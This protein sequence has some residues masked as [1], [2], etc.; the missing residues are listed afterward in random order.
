MLAIQ[1]HGFLPDFGLVIFIFFLQRLDF[2]LKFLHFIHRLVAHIAQRPE[3]DLDN[4]GQDNNR[5]AVVL[6]KPKQEVENIQS[7]NS[8]PFKPA[9]IDGVFQTD[10][11]C[12]EEIILFG[13]E[14]QRI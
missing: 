8:Q 7:G 13:T 2:R 10:T 12:A 1:G 6:N 14:V 11:E 9:E 3:N 4:G 5:D